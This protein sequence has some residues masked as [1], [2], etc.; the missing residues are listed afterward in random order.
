MADPPPSAPPFPASPPSDSDDEGPARR[1][2]S[3]D[4]DVAVTLPLRPY[5]PPIDDGNGGE[6]PALQYWPFSTSDLY[7]WKNNN[8]PF[9]EDPSK[10]T[11]LMDSLMFSHQPTWDDCQQLLGTLFTTEERGRILVEARKLV[12]GPDGQPTPLQNLIDD[13]FP[14]NRPT[15]DPNSPQGRE[16]LSI[17][18]RTLMAGLRAA[19]R[20]PTNLAKVREVIQG[21]TETPAAFLE[22]VMEAYRRYS[23]FDP[24]SE[25][26]QGTVAMTFIGQS[27]PDI[28]KKL[29]RSEG[30]PTFNL[31]DL[32]KEAEKVYFKRETEEEKEIKKEK[33]QAREFGKIL[34]TVVTKAAQSE[35][36]EDKK[37][38]RRPPLDPDQCA[39]CK[40]KGHRIRECIKLM[41]KQEREK[42]K[43]SKH[44]LLALEEEDD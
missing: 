30:L 19:A 36:Q 28:R 41:R 27:A 1:T 17:Y 44:T 12:P 6:M 11:N 38:P 37:K 26:M 22:R 40:E 8:P 31:Q 29:Q 10:L 7:N 20:R 34:A 4:R 14:L 42:S 33:R 24:Q 43:T 25:Q 18:R 3:R 16:H 21:P 2:R 5:G 32:V 39:Y 15:W 35:E 9:S 23:P 13:L